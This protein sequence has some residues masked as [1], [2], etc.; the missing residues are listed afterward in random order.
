MSYETEKLE[1][2]VIATDDL[3]KEVVAFANTYGGTILLGINKVGEPAPLLDVDDTY[4]RVTNGIR[5][6]I[7][8]DVTIFVKYTLED[9]Q[10]VRIEIGEGSYKPYYLKAKGLKPSGV[11]IRQGTSSVPASPEQIRQMI[12]NADGDTFED[13]RSLEQDLTFSYCTEVFKEHKVEFGEDKYNVL[14]IHSRTQGLY[15]NLGLLLSDQCTHTIKVAVFAD[16]QNTVFRDRKEF[17]GSVFEQ[18]EETFAY[19]QLVNQNR[20]VIDGL[21]RTDY[22]DYPN[23]AVREALLNAITHRDYSFSGS[24]IINVNDKGIEFIS[25]GGLLPG[26]SQEDIRNGISQSRNQNLVN[27]FHRLNFIESY[28][29]GIRRIFS[30]YEDSSVLPE[31]TVTPNSF[32]ITLPN[33]NAV[34]HQHANDSPITSQMRQLLDILSENPN[35]TDDE[36]QQLLNIKRTR[37]YNLTK[38]MVEAGLIQIVGRGNSKKYIPIQ[39]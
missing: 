14:G 39:K 28:G 16:E 17:T 38:Q 2:K 34:P 32:K 6:A 35:T 23:D 21:T 26:I 27:V 25:I 9:N 24:I 15:T 8:P 1:F 36:F 18:M 33:L 29:T 5:D 37:F 3:Y 11:Y 31:I 30:L 10:V 13:L 7:A 19:L 20:S 4:T 22:W 12:K